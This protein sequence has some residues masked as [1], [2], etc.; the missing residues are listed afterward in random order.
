MRIITTG[1]IDAY[2]A[3]FDELRAQCQEAQRIAF[4]SVELMQHNADAGNE[5]AAIAAGITV[6]NQLEKRFADLMRR[7]VNSIE[8][9]IGEKP[10][11]GEIPFEFVERITRWTPKQIQAAQRRHS[12]VVIE[13]ARETVT[14]AG[15]G[16]RT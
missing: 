1:D 12:I 13:G 2:H 6:G 9:V 4:R 11:P 10:S 8:H 15:T 16:A 14:G 5:D 3:L 7:F